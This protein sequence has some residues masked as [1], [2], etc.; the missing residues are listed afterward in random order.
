[1]YLP[2][3]VGRKQGET[4]KLGLRTRRPCPEAGISPAEIP[5]P[6][7]VPVG[8][9]AEIIEI[10]YRESAKI[11]ARPDMI[12]PARA[13]HLW[14][15]GLRPERRDLHLWASTY[16]IVPAVGILYRPH[17]QGREARRASDRAADKVRVCGQPED[18]KVAGPDNC[19]VAA[20]ARRR[21]DRMIGRRE[22]ITLLGGAAV[23]ALLR[24]RKNADRLPPSKMRRRNSDAVVCGELGVKP[25][26]ISLPL[27]V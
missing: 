6:G 16:R 14:L 24:H 11:L 7:L 26:W 4:D 25:D 12:A 2:V 8:T 10:L 17:S 23:L 27:A 20:C 15:A 13:S 18:R 5:Q 22:F 1:M 21:G 19:A 9:S 3:W